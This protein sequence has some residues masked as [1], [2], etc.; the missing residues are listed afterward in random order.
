MGAASLRK[1]ALAS[2]VF[3]AFC[4]SSVCGMSGE[5]IALA[6]SRMP[7]KRSPFL[8]AGSSIS[9]SDC[10]RLNRA[11]RSIA[12]LFRFEI[13]D[14]TAQIPSTIPKNTRIGM[15]SVM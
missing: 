12:R 13:I 11:K 2:L 6:A 15:M 14:S 1:P 5:A 8:A 9:A 7:W 4:S 3:R 10:G